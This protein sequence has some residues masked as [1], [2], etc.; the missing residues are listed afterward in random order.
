MDCWWA[1]FAGLLIVPA[2]VLA[3]VGLWLVWNLL[4]GR[5]GWR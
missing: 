4:N 1:V 2:T 3:A 5:G